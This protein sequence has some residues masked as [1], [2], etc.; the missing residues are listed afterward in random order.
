[1]AIRPIASDLTSSSFDFLSNHEKNIYLLIL[2][3]ALSNM[4]L[5]K[6]ISESES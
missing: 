3:E 2:C 6:H 1:M 4:M 5:I